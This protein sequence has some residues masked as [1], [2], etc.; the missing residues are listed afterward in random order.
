MP[1]SEVTEQVIKLM[2]E[3]KNNEEFIDKIDKM[4]L[5]RFK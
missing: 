2:T 3:T 5:A 1:V 4:F